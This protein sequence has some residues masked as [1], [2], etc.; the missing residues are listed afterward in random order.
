[1]EEKWSD[2]KNNS[3]KEYSNYLKKDRKLFEKI[4]LVISILLL[5]VAISLFLISAV[6]ASIKNNAGIYV[7]VVALVMLLLGVLIN[8]IRSK[9]L[10]RNKTIENR[11]K[12]RREIWD[13]KTKEFLKNLTDLEK[14]KFFSSILN[15]TVDKKRRWLVVAIDALINAIL[16]VNGLPGYKDIQDY[17]FLIMI[18]LFFIILIMTII[19]NKVIE[20]FEETIATD[21]YQEQFIR[22]YI[23]QQ[24]IQ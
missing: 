17:P 18:G 10:Q 13:K 7:Y 4:V 5:I 9:V 11:E 21:Y 3:K 19:T 1:M 20:L 12:K 14:K 6:L 23:I 15:G 16:I 24:L 22:D 8:L 2:L